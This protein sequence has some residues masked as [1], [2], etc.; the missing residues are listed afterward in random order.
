MKIFVCTKC[1]MYCNVLPAQ[2]SDCCSANVF[3]P[4]KQKEYKT[5]INPAL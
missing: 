5:Y 1:H 2:L 4:A 3:I